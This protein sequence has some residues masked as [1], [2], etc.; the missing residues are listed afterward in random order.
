MTWS[1]G[2]DVKPPG[3]GAFFILIASVLVISL[4]VAFFEGA[5]PAI[6]PSAQ[7]CQMQRQ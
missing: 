2:P 3:D 4:G 1:N 6:A 7:P 5:K